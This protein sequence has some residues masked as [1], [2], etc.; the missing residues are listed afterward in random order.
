[1]DS[2]SKTPNIVFEKPE[3]ISPPTLE[4]LRKIVTVFAQKLYHRAPIERMEVSFSEVKA[5]FRRPIAYI[6]TLK[7][8]FFSGPSLVSKS[9][10]KSSIT[11][12][13]Q[14]IAKIARQY[15]RKIHREN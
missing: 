14:A 3:K 7:V 2:S 11:S 1:M 15:Q 4:R 10:H 13:H 5:S 12:L 8:K 6:T 9:E